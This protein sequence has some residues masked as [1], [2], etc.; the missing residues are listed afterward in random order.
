MLLSLGA[1]G[2]GMAT[3]S[4][5][6]GSYTSAT[7]SRPNVLFISI[8]DLRP[9][10]GCYGQDYMLSPNMDKV[11][12]EGCVFTRSHCQVPVCGASRSSLLTGLRPTRKRFVVKNASPS[13]DAP[14]ITTLPEHFK[15][16]GYY[17]RG[18]GKVFHTAKDCSYVWSVPPYAGRI[19]A[20]NW[21]DY[22]T[23]E[24]QA[25]ASQNGGWGPPTERADIP[26]T[27]YQDGTIC[28]EALEEIRR[29][30]K[31]D[32]P[33]FVAVGFKKPHTPFTAPKRYWDLYRRSEIDLADNPFA[34]EDSPAVA[35]HNSGEQRAYVGVPKSGAFPDDLQRELIHGYY[36]CV[37][38]ADTLVG[39]LLNEL[40]A[41]GL[42]DN[43]IVV[44]WGDHG[45]QLGEHGLWAKHCTFS[46]SLRAPLIVKVPG[47]PQN[48]KVD[49]LTE[50]VD[51]YPTLCELC[52]IPKPGHQ[53]E[54]SSFVP[55]LRD[56]SLV[57]KTATFSRWE[58]GDSIRTDRYRYTEFTND[59]GGLI[60][61]MLY[62]HQVDP[63]ENVNVAGRAENADLVRGLSAQLKA[64]WR[65]ALPPEYPTYQSRPDLRYR[66]RNSLRP[67]REAQLYDAGGRRS[68]GKSAAGVHIRHGLKD[69]TERMLSL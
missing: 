19:N 49:Q 20:G 17:A 4:K 16:N 25:I 5:A 34:P 33:F 35:L 64:G 65:E 39:K 46:T 69:A 66:D 60:G 54:G 44:I 45:Y 61:R 63:A 55:L 8:D 41:Q 14:G 47:Y 40:K 48:V 26:D 24:A 56:Q 32:K 10:L 51:I 58:V 23:K 22:A 12:S 57:W 30:A 3:A 6:F 13:K 53:L 27:G 18:L 38:Y 36:A 42:E 37:A 67:E 50:F 68:A 7:A 2:V 1:A 11:A 21:R 43:T 31:M 29:V 59:N 28:A 52:D 62:D 15:D 9:Q